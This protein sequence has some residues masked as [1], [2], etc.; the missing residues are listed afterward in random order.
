MLLLNS[1]SLAR[2][3]RN[4]HI[5]HTGIKEENKIY[6]PHNYLWSSA[7]LETAVSAKPGTQNKI[8][9][10][11]TQIKSVNEGQYTDCFH[12]FYRSKAFIS[13]G[14]GALCV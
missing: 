8:W 14:V 10:R 3:G 6:L 2:N 4:Y 11:I 12:A 13:R 5:F 1:L 9:N 7:V